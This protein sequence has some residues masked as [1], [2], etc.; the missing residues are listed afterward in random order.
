MFQFA[1]LMEPDQEEA[2][3]A[4]IIAEFNLAY[5]TR[6][7]QRNYSLIKYTEFVVAILTSSTV[8]SLLFSDTPALVPKIISSL[9]ALGSIA[10]ATLGWK[11]EAVAISTT[12]GKWSELTQAYQLLWNR[13]SDGSISAADLRK[14]L[15]RLSEI[16]IVA[17][18]GEPFIT[19]REKLRLRCFE[20]VLQTRGLEILD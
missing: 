8:G 11:K 16:R 4:L 5:W 15:K 14:E 12:R 19:M 7:G 20:E 1:T 18:K 2:W 13:I 6:L 17:D 10:L 3:N 9:A